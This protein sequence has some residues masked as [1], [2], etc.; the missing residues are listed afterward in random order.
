MR[1][2][3]DVLR[4]LRQEIRVLL[5]IGQP[6]Q[7]EDRDEL[8]RRG[9]HQVSGPAHLVLQFLREKY[10]FERNCHGMHS[11]AGGRCDDDFDFDTFQQSTPLSMSWGR[12]G[13]S[14]TRL[15]VI[16]KS[17]DDPAENERNGVAAVLN[18]LPRAL[19][20][21]APC[22]KPNQK[23]SNVSKRS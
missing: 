14:V 9:Q 8:H 18:R 16:R 7:L 10:S 2:N 15:H 22:L 5:R 20:R 4:R 12:Y 3:H 13:P 1:Q 19:L 23:A 11:F 6:A 21:L 17:N